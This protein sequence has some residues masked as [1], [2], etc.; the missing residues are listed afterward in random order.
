VVKFAVYLVL[1]RSVCIYDDLMKSLFH[2]DL[3]IR[4]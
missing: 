2:D 3:R 4:L 1:Y